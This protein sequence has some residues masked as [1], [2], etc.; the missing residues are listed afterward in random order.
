MATSHLAGGPALLMCI[1]ALF[2]FAVMF[3]CYA[4]MRFLWA[5]IRVRQRLDEEFSFFPQS[6]P[7]DRILEGPFD[8]HSFD[9]SDCVPPLVSTIRVDETNYYS[10]LGRR[11]QAL[12]DMPS[13]GV[14]TVQ[15]M[16]IE[17]YVDYELCTLCSR[18]AYNLGHPTAHFGQ[19]PHLKKTAKAIFPD[20]EWVFEKQWLTAEARVDG[21]SIR[22]VT[23][24]N[25]VWFVYGPS[26]V[27]TWLLVFSLI[28]S[29]DARLVEMATNFGSVVFSYV[30]FF[31]QLIAVL[32]VLCFVYERIAEYL[33]GRG[34]IGFCWTELFNAPPLLGAFPTWG[35]LRAKAVT[36]RTLGV[37][38]GMILRRGWFT[39]HVME[40]NAHDVR[41]GDVAVPTN[42]YQ[43]CGLI[44]D[45]AIVGYSFE[46]LMSDVYEGW[47]YYYNHFLTLPRCVFF[48]HGT[49]G[50][51]IPVEYYVNLLRSCGLVADRYDNL[52]SVEG[53]RA[54]KYV[55]D[56]EFWKAAKWLRRIGRNMASELRVP[57]TLVFAPLGGFGFTKNVVSFD[58]SPPAWVLKSW[59]IM[60]DNT[61]FGRM[62]NIGVTITQFIATPDIRIGSFIGCAPRSCDGFQLLK[63]RKNNGKR[64]LLIA[65]GSSSVPEPETV[66]GFDYCDIWST[67]KD[68]K[69]QFEPRTNHAEM[70]CDYTHVWC[71][72]GAGTMATAAAAGCE[73]KSL[74]KFIDRHYKQN[75]SQMFTFSNNHFWFWYGMM[76]KMVWTHRLLLM[77]RVIWV[78][79]SV[80][81][82][83]VCTVLIDFV[84]HLILWWLVG[85]WVMNVLVDMFVTRSFAGLAA[86]FLRH[87]IDCI[88]DSKIALFFLTFAVQYWY[89]TASPTQL[90]RDLGVGISMMFYGIYRAGTHTV[91][92]GM[93]SAGNPLVAIVF[94][95]LY[96]VFEE[97]YWI[98][99]VEMGI[100]I[101]VRL[102]DP[103]CEFD[104]A[105][106][107][108][109]VKCDGVGWMPLYHVD[110]ICGDEVAGITAASPGEQYKPKE[111]PDDPDVPNRWYIPDY[112]G[113]KRI[114][115]FYAD[116]VSEREKA[117]FKICT[118]LNAS[119]WA[120]FKERLRTMD[121]LAYTGVRN[122]Q[123][124]ALK[125][126]W[127]LPAGGDLYFI[128]ALASFSVG[129]MLVALGPLFF[130][131][132]FGYGM[133]AG[134]LYALGDPVNATWYDILC[135]AFT[136]SGEL[137]NAGRNVNVTRNQTSKYALPV[138]FKR[139]RKSVV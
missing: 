22:L 95:N 70:M 89:K 23:H 28:E 26:S 80:V 13:A 85:K 54:L 24:R 44:P 125:A 99:I 52:S 65:L 114:C 29:V 21:K 75:A 18:F 30:R 34:Y 42:P 94:A 109:I 16:E 123:T 138:E 69:F 136:P 68:T 73:V 55:E 113:T 132:L 47:C 135:L 48:T 43:W 2:F 96:K 121:G 50:D 111:N 60:S 131:A 17:P 130:M 53:N 122:C 115:R 82:A 110:Y 45:D 59:N 46:S 63:R 97:R 128:A 51:V 100:S 36:D 83:L 37:R 31:Q 103:F 71:H 133:F 56:D 61:Q 84:R 124:T 27:V 19:F 86:T 20:L 66:D 6:L 74:S 137:F 49:H 106:Y 3:W 39:W 10:E 64:K 38:E 139:D 9:N 134:S 12:I 41:Y 91:L 5:H 120:D 76:G 40:A 119:H 4:K 67:R 32:S 117:D 108:R 127:Q 72:G 25:K 105:V 35:A 11:L 118:S 78:D 8:V 62:L 14:R 87:G 102:C 90:F 129:F 112:K 81:F 104:D 7:E 98:G 79:F 57:N 15:C 88:K 93:W 33:T 77:A 116:P 101:A 58:L 1:A 126:R 92:A 107:M